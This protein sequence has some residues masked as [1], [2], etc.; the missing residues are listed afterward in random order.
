MKRLVT[1]LI[2][3]IALFAVNSYAQIPYAQYKVYTN[4]QGTTSA[5]SSGWAVETSS[6]SVYSI[7]NVKL[8][9]FRLLNCN[10]TANTITIYDAATYSDATLNKKILGK[11][12][13]DG[14]TTWVQ[15]TG[16]YKIGDLG[17]T[18]NFSTADGRPILLSK[19]IFVDSTDGAKAF[20]FVVFY[21][22]E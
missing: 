5:T 4:V 6:S 18:L 22:K 16:E 1:T 21:R 7:S 14:T 8:Y 13:Y 20:S 10:T 11:I 12:T 17:Y 3:I 15:G 2:G 19:G 9:Q